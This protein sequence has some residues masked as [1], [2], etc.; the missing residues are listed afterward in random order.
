[1]CPNMEGEELE[2]I[3]IECAGDAATDCQAFALHKGS[4]EISSCPIIRYAGRVTSQAQAQSFMRPPRPWRLSQNWLRKDES[5]PEIVKS[6]CVNS[7]CIQ[8]TSAGGGG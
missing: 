6:F 5:P 7:A 4:S 1:M 2:D 3:D 8:P